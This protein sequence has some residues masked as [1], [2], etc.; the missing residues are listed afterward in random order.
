[1]VNAGVE[2]V[3]FCAD[4]E[5]GGPFGYSTADGYARMKQDFG[6]QGAVVEHLP[7]PKQDEP[8]KLYAHKVGG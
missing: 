6:S 4:D 3:I 5:I 7:L 2:R 1:M 8:F